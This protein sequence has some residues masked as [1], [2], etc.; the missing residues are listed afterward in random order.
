MTTYLYPEKPSKKAYKEGLKNGEKFFA[1]EMT[2]WGSRACYN[3]T[4]TFSGPHYPKPHKYYGKAKIN[5]DGLVET[6]V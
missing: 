5:S 4:V 2:P 3:E 1:R 6:I